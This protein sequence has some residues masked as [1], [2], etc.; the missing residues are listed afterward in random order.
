[1]S[2][3]TD[4]DILQLHTIVEEHFQVFKGVKNRGLLSS[5]AER[6][7]QQINSFIPF[8]NVFKK[9]ASLME[10]IIRM[11]PFYDGNKRTGLLAAV[12]YL[13]ING[14]S[15]AIP[16]S[17]I[18]FTVTI[19]KMENNDTESNTKII[20]II[21]K[22][23]SKH[24]AKPNSKMLRLKESWYVIFPM[25]CLLYLAQYGFMK[26]LVYSI[27]KKWFAFDIYPEYK[28][29][30][31]EVVSFIKELLDKKKCM[32]SKEIINQRKPRL[33]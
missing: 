17:S 21:A 32:G 22:W 9:A 18:R 12:Y 5:I 11:H 10:G 30:I 33:E 28:R 15:I 14:Y 27:I 2:E 3:L 13:E 24:S 1:M 26:T 23:F 29:E 19:A 7:S 6:P 4:K 25:K 31:T 8:D 16:F 20:N